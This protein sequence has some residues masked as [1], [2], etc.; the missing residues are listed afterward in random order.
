MKEGLFF[1]IVFFVPVVFSIVITCVFLTWWK[2]RVQKH[3]DEGRTGAC[4][5]LLAYSICAVLWVFLSI[6][7]LSGA[8]YA[9]Q[10]H[11]WYRDDAY[12]CAKQPGG[13]VFEVACLIDQNISRYKT[14]VVEVVTKCPLLAMSTVPC[15]THKA[16][17]EFLQPLAKDIENK[18]EAMV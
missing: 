12:M 17:K 14:Y 8:Y 16:L 1:G 10:V 18:L 6:A 4:T 15:I 13:L 11:Q 9:S 2:G 3:M 7:A 5:H